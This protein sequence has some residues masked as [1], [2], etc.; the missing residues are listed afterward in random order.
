[1]IKTFLDE[2]TIL[3]VTIG[4]LE[5]TAIF[6]ALTAGWSQRER[7]RT[8]I[9]TVA[10]STA[11]LV[12]FALFGDDILRDIGIRLSSLKIAGGILLMIIGI[13]MVFAPADESIAPKSA[14]SSSSADIAVFPLA[15]PLIAGPPSITAIIVI[16]AKAEGDVVAETGNLIV[17]L[18]VLALTLASLCSAKWIER[19]LRPQGIDIITRVLGMVLCALAAEFVV[20]GLDEAALFQQH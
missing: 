15:V 17:L 4:P 10:I 1:L 14:I 6:S 12:A 2:F 13:R 3:F 19:V 18:I 11:I 7:I 8:A 5:A 20:D 9:R 16:M